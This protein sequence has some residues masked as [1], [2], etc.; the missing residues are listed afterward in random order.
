MERG[1]GKKD[2]PKR[3]ESFGD[4]GTDRR[5]DRQGTAKKKKSN[6]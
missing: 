3:H 2:V 4:K 5:F 6:P 1:R